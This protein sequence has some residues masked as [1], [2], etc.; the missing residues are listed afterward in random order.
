[1]DVI[2]TN[3]DLTCK[4]TICIYI[5][6]SLHRHPK[7]SAKAEGELVAQANGATLWAGTMGAVHTWHERIVN[8]GK[9][10]TRMELSVELS[11][12][13]IVQVSG[14]KSSWKP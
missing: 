4:Y 6:L 1:M 11:E 8:H 5:S 9:Y 13:H 14:A 3:F 10:E 7:A 12:T 2:K